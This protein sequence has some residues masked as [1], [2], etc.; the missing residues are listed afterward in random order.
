MRKISALLVMLGIASA[1]LS[2]CS[3]SD[4]AFKSTTPAAQSSQP[5]TLAAPKAAEDGLATEAVVVA[6]KPVEA[7]PVAAVEALP[8][9]TPKTAAVAVTTTEVAKTPKLNV[10]QRLALKSVAKKLNKLQISKQTTAGT[11]EAQSLKRTSIYL[12][13]AGVLAI[14]VGIL[15]AGG[16]VSGGSGAGFAIGVALAYLGY[17]ALVVG[18]ILLIVALVRG[19]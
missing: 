14:L 4:Y 2:S 13:I 11:T 12:I 16:S 10:V 1:S 19:H 9:Q 8:A 15:I 18:I 3:R 6:P 17:I 7:A 5:M